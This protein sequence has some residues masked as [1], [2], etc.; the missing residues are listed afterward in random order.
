MSRVGGFTR[1]AA[2]VP[3]AP[4]RAAPRRTVPA[5]RDGPQTQLKS[6]Q[7][8]NVLTRHA[9]AAS[10]RP[11]CQCGAIIVCGPRR[12][13]GE[14]GGRDNQ[15]QSVKTRRDASGA[16]IAFVIAHVEG[17]NGPHSGMLDSPIVQ[18]VTPA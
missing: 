15:T 18:S 9:M 6:P 13:N 8:A 2:V 5:D 11:I 7:S 14:I 16:G 3:A 17:S 10:F 12:V 4:S 1:R